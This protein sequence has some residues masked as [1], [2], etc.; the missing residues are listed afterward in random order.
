MIVRVWPRFCE[1]PNNNSDFFDSFCVSELLLYKPFKNIQIDIGV[2]TKIIIRH[3]RS[4]RYRAWHVNKIPLA[5][6]TI[7]ED[8]DTHQNEVIHDNDMDDWDI[9]SHLVPPW[10]T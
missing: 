8:D 2:S 7:E 9:L 3:W 10:R 6:D 5:P 1:V 4:L